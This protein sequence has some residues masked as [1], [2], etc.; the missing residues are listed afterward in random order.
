MEGL[1]SKVPTLVSFL[2]NLAQIQPFICKSSFVCQATALTN[3]AIKAIESLNQFP[4]VLRLGRP[5]LILYGCNDCNVFIGCIG[6]VGCFGCTA[7]VL[8]KY[9][10]IPQKVLR[11]SSESPQKVLRKFSKIPWKV[12]GKSPESPQ[13]VLRKSSKALRSIR[14]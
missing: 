3:M 12:L 9:S 1:L 10:E 2:Y 14:K 13:K 8:R 11:K 7:S 6:C 4:P 5:W